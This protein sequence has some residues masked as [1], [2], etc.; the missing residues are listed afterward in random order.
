MD[1]SPNDVDEK[2]LKELSIRV[3]E[4]SGGD[5]TIEIAKQP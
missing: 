5:K 2:Q 1:E 4:G 3:V